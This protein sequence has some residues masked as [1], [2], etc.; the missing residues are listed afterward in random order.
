MTIVRRKNLFRCLFLLDLISV[1][2]EHRGGL[3]FSTFYMMSIM[4]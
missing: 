2:D 4:S 3:D 1:H